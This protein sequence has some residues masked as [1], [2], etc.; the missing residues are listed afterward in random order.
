MSVRIPLRMK[1][2][3][4]L[5]TSCSWKP[6]AEQDAETAPFPGVRPCGVFMFFLPSHGL[7]GQGAVGI[8]GAMMSQDLRVRRPRRKRSPLSVW[9]G[10]VRTRVL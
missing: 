8:N 2:G 10:R 4:T 7:T 5:T 6:E 3:D 9:E 1:P